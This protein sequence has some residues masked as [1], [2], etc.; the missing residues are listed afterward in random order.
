MNNYSFNFNP[1][2]CN[3]IYFSELKI[4]LDNNYNFIKIE[5]IIFFN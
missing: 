4:L 1:K 3:K 2:D 5:I